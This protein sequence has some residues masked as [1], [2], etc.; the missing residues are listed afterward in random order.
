MV[1]VPPMPTVALPVTVN[2]PPVKLSVL[3]VVLPTVRVAIVLL[4]VRLEKVTVAP[5]AATLIV[6]VSVTFVPGTTP[7]VHVVVASQGPVLAAEMAY[8]LEGN[9][10]AMTVGRESAALSAINSLR[11][12]GCIAIFPYFV[13][14]WHVH[15]I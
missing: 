8:A 15:M 9:P 1:S 11:C 4:P 6:A 5:G 10:I 7:P 14:V 2:A 12:L 3:P 13:I